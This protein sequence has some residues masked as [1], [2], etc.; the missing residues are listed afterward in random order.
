MVD[1]ELVEVD[2]ARLRAL[3]AEV[4][5]HGNLVAREAPIAKED[6]E[7]AL[8]TMAKSAL[9][10]TVNDTLRALDTVVDYHVRQLAALGLGLDIVARS[11]EAAEK[12]SGDSITKS[13][14]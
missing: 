5:G 12:H 8:R 9:A 2:P 13:V 14:R 4:V 11:F 10:S 7:S 1:A 3:A 6:R